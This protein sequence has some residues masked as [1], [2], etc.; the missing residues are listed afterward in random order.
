[1]SVGITGVTTLTSVA[2]TAAFV[3]LPSS[4][5]SV[6]VTVAVVSLSSVGMMSA[7]VVSSCGIWVENMAVVVSLSSA[8]M[9]AFVVS[10]CGIWVENKAV[11]S[12]SS[13]TMM[14]ASVVYSC[15]SLVIAVVVSLSCVRI[16]SAFVVYSVENMSDDDSPSPDD[17]VISEKYDIYM[18]VC[19]CMYCYY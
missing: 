9:S 3:V 13:V 1:M 8:V 11:D 17:V 10:S 16:I 14:S 4:C 5:I 18:Y 19:T 7:F 2:L 12:L 6:V 15:I